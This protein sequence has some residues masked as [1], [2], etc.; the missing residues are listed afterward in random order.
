MGLPRAESVL[1][2]LGWIV[3]APIWVMGMAW[4]FMAVL[5]LSMFMAASSALHSHDHGGCD[6]DGIA[7]GSG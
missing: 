1:T 5:L 6:A 7:Y 3:H 4:L 2:S